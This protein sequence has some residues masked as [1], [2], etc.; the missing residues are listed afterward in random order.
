MDVLLSSRLDRKDATRSAA[1]SR[2]CTPTPFS[3]RAADEMTRQSGRYRCAAG[4][5]SNASAVRHECHS[6]AGSLGALPDRHGCSAIVHVRV[7]A[8]LSVIRLSSGE[9]ST[10][11]SVRSCA[12]EQGTGHFGP[13]PRFSVI[14]G[15]TF[16]TARA[17]STYSASAVVVRDSSSAV[18]RREERTMPDPLGRHERLCFPSCSSEASLKRHGDDQEAV[19]CWNCR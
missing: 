7:V 5:A 18:A 15:Q 13:I 3:S 9:W 19:A 4:K 11:T 16:R 6:G 1:G 14:S 10:P 12:H 2:P 8:E 17:R